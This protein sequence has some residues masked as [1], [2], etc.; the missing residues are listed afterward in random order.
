LGSKFVRI[1][2]GALTLICAVVQ[3]SV[4]LLQYFG[5]SAAR[6]ISISSVLWV[7]L[8]LVLAGGTFFWAVVEFH[9]LVTNALARRHL[10]PI[11][12]PRTD[13]QALAYPTIMREQ[14]ALL[15]LSS[16]ELAMSTGLPRGEAEYLLRNPSFVPRVDVERRVLQALLLPDGWRQGDGYGDECTIARLKWYVRKDVVAYTLLQTLLCSTPTNR[17]TVL[18]L[19]EVHVSTKLSGKGQTS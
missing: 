2:V 18:R 6:L 12:H 9:R 17:S 15:M 13:D 14:P 8:G 5:V 4:G 1:A 11:D 19:V 16:G 7:A 3:A 10:E